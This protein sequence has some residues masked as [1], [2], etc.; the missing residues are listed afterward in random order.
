ARART[1]GATSL[2]GPSARRISSSRLPLR[3]V[4][5]HVRSATCGSSSASARSSFRGFRIGGLL[6]LSGLLI[7][8]PV[9]TG[10]HDDF[11]ALLVAQAIFGENSTLVLG[12]IAWLAL[13]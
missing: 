8:E 4:R 10:G 12:T 2:S 6:G 13:A 11:V 7:L 5:T 3:R 1:S 9:S